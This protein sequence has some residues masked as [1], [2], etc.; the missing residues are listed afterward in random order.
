MKTITLKE[1]K[2]LYYPEMKKQ[3]FAKM[4][5]LKLSLASK[6]M[7]GNYICST[8]SKKWVELSKLIKEQY[9]FQLITNQV[10]FAKIE[11]LEKEIINLKVK[12]KSYEQQIE[13]YEQTIS[14]LISSLKI[15]VRAK[16]SIDKGKFV[17][18]KYISQ[19]RNNK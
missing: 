18:D 7:N 8:K 16:E 3:D 15:A 1:L 4:L 19:R 6:I 17:L 13:L 5:N 14:D 2:D 11:K 12:V 9:G 10:N